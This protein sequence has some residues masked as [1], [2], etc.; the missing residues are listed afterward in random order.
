MAK[1]ARLAL[2]VLRLGAASQ[3][4][5]QVVCGGLVYVAMFK[6]P[7]LGRVG[8]VSGRVGQV[9]GLV[10]LAVPTFRPPFD[11]AVTASDA[12]MTGGGLR[13]QRFHAL[14]SCSGLEPR[15]RGHSEAHDLCQIL[16]IG[17]FDGIG[18]LRV[19]LD[20]Q[21]PLAGHISVEA[22]SSAR[23]GG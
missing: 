20:L 19:A 9:S 8:Q 17:L 5:L 2:E 7:L 18:A 21:A 3:K 11:G 1:Y 12:S 14:W 6:R 4:E 22:N 13:V 23:G 16:S 15:E 10:P